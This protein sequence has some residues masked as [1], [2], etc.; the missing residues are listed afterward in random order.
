MKQKDKREGNK[1]E[2]EGRQ[3]IKGSGGKGEKGGGSILFR[4]R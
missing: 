2:K 4:S 1:I 3:W